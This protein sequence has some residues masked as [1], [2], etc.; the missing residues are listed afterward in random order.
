MGSFERAGAP[1]PVPGRPRGQTR[2]KITNRQLEVL[3]RVG[4]GEGYREVGADLG[5]SHVQVQRDYKAAL[6]DL[7]APEEVAE[8]RRLE[9]F[10]LDGYR[11]E[12]EAIVMTDQPLVSAG[13]VVLDADGKAIIDVRLKL[14]AIDGLLKLS[15]QQ[16]RLLGLNAPTQLAIFTPAAIEAELERL[17]GELGLDL[18]SLRAGVQASIGAGEE[19]DTHG[20]AR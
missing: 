16:A 6:R 13:K 15:K 14:S 8:A 5:V 2:Q 4:E 18:A 10:R 3:R 12:L 20:N 11:R 7:V 19:E 9:L 1:K 17:A